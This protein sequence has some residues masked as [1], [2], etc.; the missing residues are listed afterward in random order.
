MNSL[1]I[2]L[3]VEIAVFSF[4]GAN[5]WSVANGFEIVRL[6]AE[7]GLLALALT[8]VLLTGGIDLSVGSMMGLCA[9]S[10]GALWHDLGVPVAACVVLVLLIGALGGALNA[11]LIARFRITP[12][13]VTLGTYSLFRGIAEGLTGGAVNYTGFPPGFLFLGQGYAGGVIPAQFFVLAAVGT[14][15]WILVHRSAIGRTLSAIGFS[16]EG[17][18][19]AGIPVSRR[20]ALIYI[21]SGLTASLTAVIYVSHLG[22]AKSDAGMGYELIAITAVVLGGTSIFGGRGTVTGT[23]LGLFAIVILQ[24]GL[25]LSA[26][27]AELTGVLIAILLIATILLERAESMRLAPLLG[28]V[29]AGTIAIAAFAA[30]GRNSTPSAGRH[31]VAGLMPKAKGDPYF[32][33]C[34]KGAE[35]AA[36]ALGIDLIWDGPTELDPAKQNEVVEGWI[37]KGVDVIAVSVENRA[38]IST[39][40]RKARSRG[41]KVIAWDAD[42]EPDARD[43]FVNQA[44]PEGIGYALTDQ[45]AKELGDR[46][47]FAI[48]TGALSSANQN[49]WI[50]HIK[51]RLA[52]KY[53]AIKL[54]TIEPS[55]DDRDKAFA[56]TQT[57][58][59]VYPQAKLIMGISAPAVPGA[60]E[61]VK[62]SGR[63]D[64][65]VIGLSLPSLCRPYVHA[66]FIDAVILWNTYDLGYLTVYTAG[67]LVS[68]RLKPGDAS[69]EAGRLGTV[70]IRGDQVI[71]GKP[72]TFTRENIDRFEF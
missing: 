5:F 14:A 48:I 4:T 71:L 7:I 70:E 22:Q 25:R 53:P 20:L 43:F 65:K 33:S 58:L 41:I 23:L 30:H 66:G 17:A 55:D 11:L 49:E 3:A 42:A 8:P 21:L 72:F 31:I 16:P 59:K 63:T 64:V 69:F 24:N 10:F 27:P 29:L 2:L 37:T 45:A 47:E 54:L 38:A 15:Y 12:L 39:V 19:Y 46:G 50:T 60:A 40:L 18:R 62:Q 67:G 9:V 57:V 52:E 13:I 44:T 51:A 68:G 34:R 35:E 32:V 26:L 56:R 1:L 36:R 28:A 6:G 61:G